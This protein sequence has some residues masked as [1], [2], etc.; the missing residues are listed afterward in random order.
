MSNFGVWQEMETAPRD[1]TVILVSAGGYVFMASWDFDCDFP[2][3]DDDKDWI[4]LASYD[5]EWGNYSTIE[6]IAWMP[7]P[8]PFKK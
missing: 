3:K 2:G 6:P 8:E 1:G 5:S 4:N 7:L